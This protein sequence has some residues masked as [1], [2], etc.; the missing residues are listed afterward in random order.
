MRDV[1]F[2]CGQA[3]SA[4]QGADMDSFPTAY[5]NVLEVKQIKE[6]F[7]AVL[8]E[9]NIVQQKSDDVTI[10]VFGIDN[11]KDDNRQD[12][13]ISQD[14]LHMLGLLSLE[15][16]ETLKDMTQ[17]ISTIVKNELAAKG[18]ELYD[19]KLEFGRIGDKVVL[20]DEISGGNMRVYKDGRIVAPLDIAKI[21]FN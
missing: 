18:A 7:M 10:R 8:K 14:A 20:M 17:K 2:R 5:E 6:F 21:I 9:P 12:P 19:I 1:D 3:L 4:G 11:R 13:P 15:E 16:Y